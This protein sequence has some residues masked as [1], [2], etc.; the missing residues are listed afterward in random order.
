MS[1]KTI[2]RS[3]TVLA[4]FTRY[5]AEDGRSRCEGCSGPDEALA[6]KHN[7]RHLSAVHTRITAAAG[8]SAHQLDADGSV[9]Y[10][11]QM[12][13]NHGIGTAQV[14]ENMVAR[15]GVEPPTPA[16]SGL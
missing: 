6:G 8:R 15:D 10:W 16:F 9:A 12:E 5:L 13:P 1:D 3:T 7:A 11:N 2:W 4:H 14:I